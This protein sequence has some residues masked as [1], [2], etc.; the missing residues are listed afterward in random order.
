MTPQ[1]VDEQLAKLKDFQRKTVEYVFRRFYRDDPPARRF[2]VADEVGLGKTI[3]ARGL[4]AKAIHELEEQGVRRI[5]II[6]VCS[7]AAIAQQNINRLN[8]L[9]HKEHTFATRLTLLPLQLGGLENNRV[10]FVSFTPGTTFDLKS[11]GGIK[12]E[13]ALLYRMLVEQA[14]GSP[15]ALRN[16]LQATAGAESWQQYLAWQV[17]NGL[18][19]DGKLAESFLEQLQKDQLWDKLEQALNSFKRTRDNVPTSDI[20]LR[21][22]VIGGLRQLLARNCVKALE[23]DLI[24]LDEF[25]RFKDL[26][27]GDS[28]ATELA[29]ALFNFPQARVLLLSATPYRMLTLA[30]EMEDDHQKDFLETVRFLEDTPGDGIQQLQHELS[31][32][33]AALLSMDD[34]AYGR[35]E[36]ARDGIEKQLRAVMVRTERVSSTV[37]RDAMLSEQQ[38]VLAPTRSELDEGVALEQLSRCLALPDAVEYWKSAPCALSFMEKYVLKKTLLEQKEL[39]KEASAALRIANRFGLRSK[40]IQQ[41]GT[42]AMHNAR[43]RALVDETL[44]SNN[45]KLLWL[46]PSLPYIV[47]TGPYANL[48]PSAHSKSLLFSSWTMVPK[49]VAAMLSYEAERKMLGDTTGLTYDNL[50]ST[51]APLLRFSVDKH[52]GPT[53]MPAL[54]LL[55]PCATL[56][57]HVDP[58]ALALDLGDGDPAQLQD[59]RARIAQR[60]RP[61]VGKLVEQ[62]GNQGSPRVDERWYWAA[63]ALL[64]L[65]HHNNVIEWLAANDGF[66]ACFDA[67]DDDEAAESSLEAGEKRSAFQRH[68]E[69]LLDVVNGKQ[70][71]DR[72]PEDLEQ[73]IADF[74]LASPAVCAA[75][76]IL[77]VSR[78]GNAWDPALLAAAASVAKGFRTL[79][80]I[81]ETISMLR[82]S[83]GDEAY[84]RRVL[85]YCVDG[86]LQSTLDEYAHLLVENTG[87]LGAQPDDVARTISQTMTDAL[88]P[89]SASLSIDE[90]R[91]HD[92]AV[93]SHSF[94]VRCRY[95]LRFGDIRDEE[96]STLSRAET[97]REAFN[98]P[99]RPFVLASTSVGQ[100]GLDFHSYCHVVYHWNLPSNPVDLEQREGRVHRYKGHAVRRN[101]ARHF[102]LS[103]LRHHWSGEGDPWER[104][105]ELASSERPEGANELVPY[106]IFETEGGVR[107]ERRVP[108]LALSRETAQLDKLKRELAVYRLAFGQPRQEDLL[109]YLVGR[110]NFDASESDRWRIRLAP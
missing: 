23:P 24:I 91:I 34:G 105:F 64:D 36:A 62:H 15:T 58:L 72:P 70:K 95:A 110:T 94:R 66:R 28:E 98:S 2:L 37:R 12:E 69:L 18:P 88:S 86:N 14:P 81:P 30:H 7:N 104:L 33:R 16:L 35:G 97:V 93:K 71:L 100:E 21:S 57:A 38:L 9:G 53:G 59:V 89:R 3:V 43:L 52:R 78:L 79:F 67:T 103:T 65:H 80:N 55:Y 109:A 11:R 106:W 5:D 45:W 27:H 10:N 54:A 99:F 6:Y 50:K 87:M 73:V 8:V 41:Y 83:D 63:P 84:W 17:K 26:L 61:L 29:R 32:F 102:G 77:R 4:I 19:F 56:V 39:S 96:S 51:R 31:N 107:V 60:V 74:A 76:A 85:D 47:P 75:R 22:Q 82:S 90:L 49:A 13:R 20:E 42:I 46:P 68:I 1:Q 108:M 40:D 44:G 92:G 25:Q 48:G 101:L